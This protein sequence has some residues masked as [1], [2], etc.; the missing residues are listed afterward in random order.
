M[1]RSATAR[2]NGGGS[3]VTC[4]VRINN[5]FPGWALRPPSLST[6]ASVRAPAAHRR[7]GHPLNC[8]PPGSTISATVTQCNG[9]VNGGGSPLRVNCTLP[10]ALRARPPVHRQPV[11]RH[12]QRRRLRALLLT[13]STSTT[14]TS[15]SSR[16]SPTADLHALTTPHLTGGTVRHGRRTDLRAGRRGRR[17]CGRRAAAAARARPERRRTACR[18]GSSARL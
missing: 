5:N 1:S 3:N 6:S 2:L 10:A 13:P 16:P 8:A 9:S 18:W 12:R 11:Q 17:C 7:A 14:T 4:S 15:P